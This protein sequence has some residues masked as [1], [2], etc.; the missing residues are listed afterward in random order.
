VAVR[1]GGAVIVAVLVAMMWNS[2][3]ERWLRAA[4]SSAAHGVAGGVRLRATGSALGDPL[5]ANA[6]GCGPQPVRSHRERVDALGAIGCRG[7]CAPA[8]DCPARRRSQ[9]LG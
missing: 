4:V 2:A 3:S 6:A 7:R 9:Q 8:V 1:A 5:L